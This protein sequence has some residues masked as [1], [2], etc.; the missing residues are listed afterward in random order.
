[1]FYNAAWFVLYILL[2]FLI[3]DTL[4]LFA[5]GKKLVGNRIMSEKLSNG[6]ENEINIVINNQY[7]FPI[8]SKI[9]DEI[10]FQFQQ[11]NF[12][13]KR[14]IKALGKDNYTY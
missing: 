5:S 9:I 8:Y 3:I 11:R 7:S 2:A 4:L 14:K 13:V 12:E 1:M 6:D 10:P